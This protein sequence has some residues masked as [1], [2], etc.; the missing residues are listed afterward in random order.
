MNIGRD[1]RDFIDCLRGLSILRVVLGH[2]GLFWLMRPYSEF[3]HALLPLLF[4]VSGA[5]SFGSFLRSD[6]NRRFLLRRLVVIVS[7]YYA[8][9]VLALLAGWLGQQALSY[10]PSG[11]GVIRLLFLNPKNG[12]LFFPIGQVWFLHALLLITFVSIPLFSLAR[13]APSW[14]W[15]PVIL[16]LMLGTAQLFTNL[17]PSLSLLGHNTYQA[18]SNMGFFFFGSWYMQHHQQPWLAR[19]LPGMAVL[20][21]VIATLALWL[22]GGEVGLSH[23]SYAPDLYYLACSFC[24]LAL[25]LALKPV[26]IRLFFA[27]PR[28]KQFLLFTS[29]HAYSIFLLHSFFIFASEYWLGLANVSG[30]P[31]YAL[32]KIALVLAACYLCCP[33][34]TRLSQLLSNAV[35]KGLALPPRRSMQR[36]S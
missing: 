30:Q 32:A 12:D 5:V 9:V 28:L 19:L 1:E 4:F 7:P 27:L 35:L 3:L 22:S 21:A 8:L 29:V 36:A 16:S 26:L 18:W 17:S 31:L 15:L 11:D 23:H 10:Q 13:R 2:L 14:L 6:D 33:L 34:L 24:A 20:A 25:I